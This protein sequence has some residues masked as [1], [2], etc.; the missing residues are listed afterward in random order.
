MSPGL[1]RHFSSGKLDV[2]AIRRAIVT[3]LLIYT[4]VAWCTDMSAACIFIED[5]HPQRVDQ[6]IDTDISALTQPDIQDLP[7]FALI[8][9]DGKRALWRMLQQLN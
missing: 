4:V 5:A 9:E 6:K 8:N 1:A 7:Y 3:G 2:L